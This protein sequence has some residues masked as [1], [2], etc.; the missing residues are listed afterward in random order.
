MHK[1]LIVDD[2]PFFLHGFSQYLSE[3][4]DFEIDSALSVDEAITKIDKAQ[5]SLAM[6]DVTMHDGGG[7]RVLRHMRLH[8]PNVPAMF[9]TVHI[10]PEQTIDALRLGIRGIALK[11]SDP[12]LIIEA[13]DAVLAGGK[14]FASGVTEPALQLSIEK[15]TGSV[16]SDDLLTKRELEIVDLVCKG[17]RNRQI[18]DHCRL[19]EGTVKV[20][21]NSVFRKLGLS[22]RSELIVKREGMRSSK[23]NLKNAH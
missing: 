23:N 17:L 10:D 7:M 19:T 18:A 22:S 9:L 8:H 16:R 21:L 13:M 11:E 3:S 14:W 20:H 15:P 2:H 4:R 1:I 5:P 6:L 12:E